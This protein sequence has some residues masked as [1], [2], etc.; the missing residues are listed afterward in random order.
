MELGQKMR[1]NRGK[2][3]QEELAEKL[4]IS[5]NTL[6]SY[7][8]GRSYPTIDT[9]KHFCEIFNLSA[10]DI[11]E[12]NDI[13]K[14]PKNRGGMLYQKLRD[15]R[16]QLGYDL[17]EAANKI[18]VSTGTWSKYENGV[19]TPPLSRFKK[20]CLEFY[21]SADYLLGLGKYASK[22]YQK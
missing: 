1:Q 5:I 20:I 16:E 15:L 9:F 22:G 10:D 19:R 7:E 11:L 21:V 13:S 2:L 4:G 3:N 18:Q 17:K 12:L 8:N 6:S 14:T